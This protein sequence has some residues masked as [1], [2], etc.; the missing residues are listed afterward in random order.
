VHFPGLVTWNSEK[1]LCK[2][3]A[4]KI[5]EASKETSIKIKKI[6]A[7]VAALAAMHFL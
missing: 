6:I 7:G 4:G 3:A 1:G 5:R 2:H